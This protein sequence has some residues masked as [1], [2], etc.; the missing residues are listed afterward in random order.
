MKKYRLK[1]LD[2]PNCAAEI[3]G[4]L[5]QL[6]GVRAVELN[7]AASILVLDT[8]NPIEAIRHVIKQVEPDAEIV[9]QSNAKSDED[10]DF[11]IKRELVLIGIAVVLFFVGLIFNNKLQATPY[12]IGEYLVLIPA[13]L[14]SGWTV[15]S[16][17]GRNIFRG[18][19]FDEHFLMTVATLGAATIHKLPEAVAVM[20]FYQIGEFF[21]GLSVS[22]SR[23]SIKSLLEIRPDSANL[24]IDGE[25]QEIKP[26]EAA[27]GNTVLVK[28][29]ERIPLD[30]EVIAGSSQVDTSALTG[31][32]V[33]R[34]VEV[35]ET[36][37]AGMINKKGTL[38]VKV[39]KPLAESSIAKILD[40]V[41]NATGKKAETEKFITTFARSYIPVVVF[42]ALAV[43]L[44]PPLLREESFSTWIYRALVLLVISC[45]CALVVSIP[46]GYFGGVGGASRRGILVKGS[47]FLDV[48]TQVKTV[49][50][51]KT[52]PLTKG[53]FRITQIVPKNGFS[54]TELLR[55]AAVVESQSNHPI[56]QS[57]RE[58]YRGD[59][60]PVSDCQEIRDTGFGRR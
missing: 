16:S 4:K 27:V 32:P 33:P 25:L 53:V 14:L 52:G 29:G 3:E 21:Q 45:P 43:A 55:L 7:F 12:S 34:S 57:I 28:P 38:T 22:R 49:V 51:D 39:I 2:C 44:L 8:D 48:L 50:F 42:G 30:G 18:K 17:A 41:E 6:G 59:I 60:T 13:Y 36:V 5:R 58:A 20:L 1:D 31:E 26:E 10:T 40:L 24:I 56:A 37:L 35:G 54:E 23:R 15:L 9:E 47:N 46:L 19:V 11:D